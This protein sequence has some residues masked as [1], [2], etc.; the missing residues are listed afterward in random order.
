MTITD[1]MNHPGLKRSTLLPGEWDYDVIP[2]EIQDAADYER[3]LRRAH[4]MYANPWFP[5]NDSLRAYGNAAILG[6]NMQGRG[7]PLAPRACR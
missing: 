1:L 5:M 4:S 2:D 6:A 3:T 7:N